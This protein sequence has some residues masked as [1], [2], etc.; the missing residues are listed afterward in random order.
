MSFENHAVIHKC[1]GSHVYFQ[2]IP[3]LRASVEFKC[4][5]HS[6]PEERYQTIARIQN[7]ASD[8]AN[9]IPTIYI[10]L[11]RT[12]S[13]TDNNEPTEGANLDFTLSY[14]QTGRQNEYLC[15]IGSVA[16]SIR[17]KSEQGLGL[18]GLEMQ[19]SRLTAHDV[20]GTISLNFQTSKPLRVEVSVGDGKWYKE[21]GETG[22]PVTGFYVDWNR[23]KPLEGFAVSYGPIFGPEQ[24]NVTTENEVRFCPPH[25]KVCGFS[26]TADAACGKKTTQD[27]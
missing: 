18:T 22:A 19:C 25:H 14:G 8:Q 1:S 13:D 24:S 11:N 6:I 7:P 21:T 17:T 26:Y 20:N 2:I 12:V 5:Y 4:C 23:G 9:H 15:P 16:T 27:F 3:A 10:G